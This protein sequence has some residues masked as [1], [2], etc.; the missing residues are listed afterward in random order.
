MSFFNVVAHTAY[1][2][3]DL[4]KQPFECR[5]LPLYDT[6]A[7]FIR[8]P[9][10]AGI[11]ALYNMYFLTEHS[12]ILFSAGRYIAYGVVLNVALVACVKQFK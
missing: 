2:R 4:D 9:L 3:D 7:A 11:S 12:S 8:N 6:L 1:D 5:R 10:F